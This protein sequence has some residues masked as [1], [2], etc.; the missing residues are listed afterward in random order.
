M[1]IEA[2]PVGGDTIS[3]SWA[4][5][6][7]GTEYSIESAQDDWTFIVR[8]PAGA[9]EYVNGTPVTPTGGEIRMNGRRNQLLVVPA[10]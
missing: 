8:P 4:E 6:A 3:F 9:T 10:H 2:L 1:S 7:R 5:P